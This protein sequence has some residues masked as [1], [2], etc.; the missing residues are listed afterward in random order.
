MFNCMYFLYAILLSCIIFYWIT[1]LARRSRRFRVLWQISKPPQKKGKHITGHLL[2][3]FYDTLIYI[4][5][6]L[7]TKSCQYIN[8]WEHIHKALH[9]YCINRISERCRTNI[10]TAV[11]CKCCF[12][13]NPPEAISDTSVSTQRCRHAVTPTTHNQTACHPQEENT[14]STSLPLALLWTL[15]KVLQPQPSASE[16]PTPQL[17]AL[18]ITNSDTNVY[19]Y[20]AI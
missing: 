3:Q 12:L 11:Q 5:I 14:V 7:V 6:Y 10:L 16:R 4:W 20:I 17:F 1:S 19:R 9:Q 13:N 18:A 8:N 15:P 2:Q